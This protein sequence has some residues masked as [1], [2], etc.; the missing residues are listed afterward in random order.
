MA[1]NC[2]ILQYLLNQSLWT[3]NLQRRWLRHMPNGLTRRPKKPWTKGQEVSFPEGA[4]LYGSQKPRQIYLL[5]AGQVRLTGRNGV[6]F[7]HLKRG[8]FFGEKSLLDSSSNH[9][10]AVALSM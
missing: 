6:I 3:Y 10:G 5:N 2:A 9:H 4:N 8:A 7:D 1:V